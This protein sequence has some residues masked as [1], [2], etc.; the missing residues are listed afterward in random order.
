MTDEED[1]L[2][3]LE[4]KIKCGKFGNCNDEGYICVNHLALAQF[5]KNLRKKSC[6]C[7]LYP[8]KYGKVSCSICKSQKLICRICNKEMRQNERLQ[9]FWECDNCGSKH[10]KC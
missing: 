4:A 7:E 1:L 5:K 3:E 8:Q 9:V 2:K 6:S 10:Y